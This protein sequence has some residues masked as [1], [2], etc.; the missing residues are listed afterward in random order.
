MLISLMPYLMLMYVTQH[1]SIE[2][3]IDC[4]VLGLEQW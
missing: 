1:N 2:R 3:T 4:P